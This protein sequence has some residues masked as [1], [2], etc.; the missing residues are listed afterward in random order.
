[1]FKLSEKLNILNLEQKFLFLATLIVPT[2]I[3]VILLISAFNKI[4]T[5]VYKF[6]FPPQTNIDFSCCYGIIIQSFYFSISGLISLVTL[7][8]SGILVLYRKFRISLVF[9]MITLLLILTRVLGIIYYY[10][11]FL[12][13]SYDLVFYNLIEDFIYF[14][15]VSFLLFW[16][17][18]ILLRISMQLLKGKIGLNR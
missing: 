6:L 10:Q 12:E 3:F 1:M 17:I 18:S 16:Q 5:E 13:H 4:Y 14:G 8:I 9:I 15:I 7:S 2:L 11:N